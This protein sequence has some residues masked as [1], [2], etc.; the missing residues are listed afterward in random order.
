MKSTISLNDYRWQ[1]PNTAQIPTLTQGG[2]VGGLLERHERRMARRAR[3]RM[4]WHR[5]I[6][7]P[8]DAAA[9]LWHWATAPA[10]QAPAVVRVS[11]VRNFAG[12]NPALD[13]RRT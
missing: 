4:A 12:G 2:L 9:W 11:R 13:L 8:I 3:W 1:Y 7:W 6:E 10:A 5:I